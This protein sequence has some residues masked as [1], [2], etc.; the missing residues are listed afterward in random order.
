MENYELKI[1]NMLGMELINTIITKQIT[2]I[3]TKNLPSGIYFFKA[4][5][6]GETIQTGKLI[7]Q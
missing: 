5:K 4:I 3:E 1:F 2:V 7:A 6:N